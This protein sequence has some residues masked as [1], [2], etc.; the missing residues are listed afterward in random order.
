MYEKDKY[1]AMFCYEKPEAELSWYHF[2]NTMRLSLSRGRVN[3]TP[4]MILK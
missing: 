4:N 2:A 3:S 1:T